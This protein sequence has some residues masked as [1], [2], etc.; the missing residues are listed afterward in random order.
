[1]LGFDGMDWELVQKLMAEGRMPNFQ[2]LARQGMAQPLGSSIPP[3]SPV[4]WSDFITGMD[5]GG[6]GIFDF[7][8][9]DPST[10]IPY[11]S[12]SRT[13]GSDAGLTLGKWRIP[14]G[15]GEVELLRHGTAFWELLRERGVPT[16]VMRIPA[17]FPPTGTADH[18][19]SGM[20]TPDIVG[21]AGTF[22]FYN[23]DPFSEERTVGGGAFY[24]V[25]YWD[26]I[27]TGEL[28]GP[29]NL[30]LEEPEDL[31]I[32]FQLF[33]DPEEPAALLRVGDEERLLAT[34][35][36]SNWVP[37]E[38]E[39]VPTQKLA[40]QARFYLRSV[41]PEVE[42]YVSPIN[43]DPYAPIMPITTPEEFAAEL[44]DATGRFYTQGFPEDTKGLTED[45]LSVD[46][47]LAQAKIAREEIEEQ[48]DP[49]LE[50]FRSGLLF[51]Y[52]GHT[53]QLGH[54][55]WGSMDPEYP[56]DDPQADPKY[57]WVIP[58]LYEEADAIV[59]KTLEKAGPE[60]TVIVMS[61]HGFAPWRRAFN[62]NTW[63][64]QEGYLVLS[65][66]PAP[67]RN[68]TIFA[69]ADWSRTRAY[70]IGV[71]GLYVNLAGRERDGVVPESKR[72]ALLE[73]IASKLEKVVDPENGQRVVRRVFISEKA[74]HDRGYMDVGPDAVIGYARTYG[75]ANASGLGELS[76]ELMA[77]N[78][79]GWTGHH[80]MDSVTVPGILFANRKLSREVTDLQDLAAAVLAEF[81]IEGFPQRDTGNER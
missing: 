73:E 6:H 69:N 21:T 20:G 67:G 24:P 22:S 42:L 39:M 23:S 3:L 40:G 43:L 19:L 28:H 41:R 27:A 74:F 9:R 48:L 59:G 76:P 47:F 25:D 55:L 17:N 11:E 29:P 70:G 50:R 45:A 51:Y 35:E 61:D 62:L 64:E 72:M 31:T 13:E 38:F 77:N 63:L 80:H 78:T 1:M 66:P 46:E 30:F 5:S 18:E 16:T 71:N 36:W 65:K 2:R 79:S 26:D 12:T 49:V 68:A 54:I 53:D 7:V 81:G 56:G 14:L 32:E 75:N 58:Q 57:A 44:A 15:G 60:A 10:R 52:F 4:A 34:D 33:V 8:H 37:V